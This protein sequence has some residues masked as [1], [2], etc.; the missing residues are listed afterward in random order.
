M[1]I[2]SI[3]LYNFRNYHQLTISFHPHLN[4][5]YGKNGVGKTNLVEAIYVLGLTRSFRLGG[6]KT[7]IALQ[8]GMCK[9]EGNVTRKYTTNYQVLISKDGKKV[10][11]NHNKVAKL[12][13]YIFK[14][15]I[16][17]F[18]PDDLRFIKD[19]P[20]TRRKTINISISLLHL[21]YVR[22]LNEYNRILKQRNAYLKQMLLNGNSSSDY[23]DILTDKL[24]DVGFK[25]YQMRQEFVQYLNQYLS[26]FYQKITGLSDL[27]FVYVSSFQDIHKEEIR[28]LYQEMLPKDLS[29]GKTNIGVHTDDFKSVIKGRDLKE[30]GSE[31]Q[32]KNAIIAYKFSEMEIFKQLKDVYPILILD[33]LFSE[34]D[35]EKIANILQFLKK[36]IQ[37]FI[38]TTD[39]E[40]FSFL[41]SF[42][43]KQICISSGK[44]VEE[45]EHERREC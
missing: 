18:H 22:Y 2:D 34:L 17:L 36:D 13:D 33:D 35:M 6:D 41:T 3:K 25:I 23:L 12:S 24:I 21:E 40:R 32:Q 4:L 39:L 16:I 42:S 31:G 15:P 43:Y 29:F 8:S 19:T 10:L 14:I 26:D 44:V 30:Y 11:I 27:E 37:T 28:S 9:I 1:K 7:L 5:I 45:S 20:S 38:T